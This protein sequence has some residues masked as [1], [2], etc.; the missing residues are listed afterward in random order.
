MGC[1]CGDRQAAAPLQPKR[2]GMV[3]GPAP[4]LK[5]KSN[6]TGR[7][8]DA[9]SQPS[10]PQQSARGV[11]RPNAL[12]ATWPREGVAVKAM[13]GTGNAVQVARAI[14]HDLAQADVPL[15][16]K[17]DRAIN[18]L[19]NRQ[20]RERERQKRKNSDEGQT[21]HRPL[22]EGDHARFLD[23]IEAVGQVGK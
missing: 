22:V 21:Q 3:P 14:P 6:E 5:G 18:Q 4:A 23:D 17:T 10:P 7:V 19:L 13:A 1:R 2:A 16:K 12:F 20:D 15:N 9:R 11:P 8:S